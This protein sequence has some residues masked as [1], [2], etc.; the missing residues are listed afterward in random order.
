[1]AIQTDYIYGTREM[2][3]TMSCP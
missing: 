1:V 2:D 3:D